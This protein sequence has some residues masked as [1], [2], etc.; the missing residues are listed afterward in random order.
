MREGNQA[1]LLTVLRAEIDVAITYDLDIPASYDFEG[2]IDLP[3]QLILAVDDPLADKADITIEI[4][5]K[6]MVL[7]DLPLSSAIFCHCFT[8]GV[9]PSDCRAC[10]KSVHLRS[11]VANGF[12]YGLLNISTRTNLAPGQR[13]CFASWLVSIADGLV[14]CG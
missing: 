1:E 4:V 2:L 13:W 8:N 6:P 12:G 5:T 14:S 11:L 10:I 7:L 9:A 3:P